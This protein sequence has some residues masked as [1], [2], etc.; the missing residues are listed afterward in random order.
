MAVTIRKSIKI[1]GACL[2]LLYLAGL[3]Y[4]LFFAENYGRGLPGLA[5]SY[6]LRPFYEI[7]RYLTCWK[8]LGMRTVF[9]NL[10]GNV[11][12]FMPFGALLPIL[13]RGVRKAW[14]VGLLSLEISALIEVSQFLFQVGCFDVDDI[15]LNTLGGLL[16]YAVFWMFS[17][18]YFRMLGRT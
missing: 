14:K 13:T 7:N 5:Y 9:L 6:N 17:R 16:G 11:I 3:I 4:F 1:S 8:I 15:I 2:F 12:G 18:I 10:A